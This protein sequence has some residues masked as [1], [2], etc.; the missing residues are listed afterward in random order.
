MVAFAEHLPTDLVHMQGVLFGL[1]DSSLLQRDPREELRAAGA[2]WVTG[3]PCLL[4]N[5]KGLPCQ[6]F[7]LTQ[8]APPTLVP[9]LG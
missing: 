9:G 1:A 6:R 2:L 5:A 7:A 4:D 8:I 3:P